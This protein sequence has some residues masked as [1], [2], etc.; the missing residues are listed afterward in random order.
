MIDRKELERYQREACEALG[1]RV[2]LS[3]RRRPAALRSPT[4]VS[5]SSRRRGWACWCTSTP[6]VLR[7]GIGDVAAADLSRASPSEHRQR[8][9]Q[10]RDVSLPPGQN[11]PLR[12][13]RAGKA[14]QLQT[15]ARPRNTFTVWHEIELNPGDQYTL[16][17]DTKHW[18]QAGDEGAIVSEFSTR[19][20]DESDIFT[21]P[22]FSAPR[23]S[24]EAASASVP[25]RCGDSAFRCATPTDMASEAGQ[26]VLDGD[27]LIELGFQKDSDQESAPR[28]SSSGPR[29]HR[30]LLQI[31]LPLA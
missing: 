25:G 22:Q 26:D 19:S 9:R 8:A 10:R 31:R 24:S 2:L 15:A 29:I 27:G 4:S 20:R 3:R 18:F 17:P 28:P 13:G 1:A 23:A 14:P 5:V 11:L 16:K 21:D 30:P 6:T 12:A 7:E